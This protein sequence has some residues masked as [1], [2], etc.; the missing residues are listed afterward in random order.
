MTTNSAVKVL[1]QDDKNVETLWAEPVGP[2]QY[3]LDNSPFWGYGVSWMDVVEAHADDNGQLR[4]SR[5]VQ[6]AGHRTLRVMFPVGVDKAPEA[7]GVLDEVVA[8]GASYEGMTPRYLAIDIPPG[9]DLMRVA[10]L[11]TERSVEWE[12]ADPPYSELYPETG[13]AEP[14]RVNIRKETGTFLVLSALIYS[15][16]LGVT[17]ELHAS[18]R[19]LAFFSTLWVVQ[20]AATLWHAWRRSRGVT[21]TGM[22]GADRLPPEQPG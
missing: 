7:Q 2:H 18:S 22:S 8:L 19:A 15:I 6:K 4:M 16:V 5:V 21:S 12:H 11:L 13:R 14:P 17:G 1:I 9:V 20:A 3:R 10:R